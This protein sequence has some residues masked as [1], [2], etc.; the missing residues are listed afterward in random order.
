MQ[1]HILAALFA[2]SAA[3]AEPTY[4]PM[5]TTKEGNY[6]VSQKFAQCSA[7]FNF[8]AKIARGADKSETANA[9]EG[10]A[11][12][13]KATGMIFLAEAMTA[14]RAIQTEKTFDSMVE[15]SLSLM[16][17][18]YESDPVSSLANMTDDYKKVCLPWVGTQEKLIE[19]LRRGSN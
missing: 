10:F 2:L 11:R 5:P 13:W 18:R 4:Q 16:N 19:L 9:F 7:H 15:G 12:G 14:D 3:L 8:L 1:S 17:A 6:A